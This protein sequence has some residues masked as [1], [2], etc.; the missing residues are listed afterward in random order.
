MPVPLVV[1]NFS[2]CPGRRPNRANSWRWAWTGTAGSATA[3]DFPG[4]LLD[5]DSAVGVVGSVGVAG[6]I[7]MA[8]LLLREVHPGRAEVVLQLF[9]GAGSEDHRGHRG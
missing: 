2:Y 4:P 7:E 8:G 1:R 3:G 6:L 9:W 5:G